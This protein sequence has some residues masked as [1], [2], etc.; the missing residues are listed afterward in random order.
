MKV[1]DLHCHSTFSDGSLTPTELVKLAEKQGLS[2]LALTDHNAGKGLYEFMAAGEK[3][4]VETIAGCEFSTD[5]NGAELHIIGLFF[6]E[7]AWLEIKEYVQE[8]RLSKRASNIKL[9]ERLSNDGYI[10]SYDEVAK[11]TN[12]D[13]FNRAHVASVL[14]EKG[15]VSSVSE[16]F[17][18]LL[19]EGG[20]Y[21]EP[22]KRLD[23]IKTIHFIKKNGAAAVLAHPFLNMNYEELEEFLPV[24]KKEG[25]DGIET[26]YSKFSEEETKRAKEL[27]K[28]FDLKESGGSD[29]HGEAK[30]NIQL[31]TGCGNL[32]IPLEFKYNLQATINKQPVLYLE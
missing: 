2:A 32:Q 25:L 4:T 19:K 24:A 18:T 27:A 10:I 29:F 21:Y 15:Y 16:A 31:G 22:P 20:K 1:C 30:P 9:L 28:R 3:S 14:F 12:A 23:T 8:M 13:G 11:K 7:S 17:K 5:Y 6:P 26:L